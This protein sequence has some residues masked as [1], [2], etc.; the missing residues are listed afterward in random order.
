M[1]KTHI[2]GIAA[3]ALGLALPIALVPATGS[4]AP[5][6]TPLVSVAQAPAESEIKGQYIVTVKAGNDAAA[7]AQAKSVRT[8][9]VYDEVINGFA[10]SLTS[11]QLAALRA[12]K[13]I[14]SIEEDQ[15][16]VSKAT[17]NNAPWGLDRIDQRSGRN[18]TYT[19]NGTGAG[20]TAYI[21][22]SGIYTAHPD[23]GN[24][25]RNVFDAFGGNGQDCNGHGTHV[26]GTV[27]G[28]VHGVAK[29]VQLRGVK[30]LNCQGSGSFSAIIAGFDWVRQNA[31]K[32]AVAN[33][34]LGGGYSAALN[35]AATALANSGVHTTVAAGN[36]NQNA[37][38]YSPASAPG[39]LSIAASDSADNKASFSNFGNCTDLYGPGVGV[40]STRMGGGTTSMSGTSMAAPHVA[41]VAALY[42]GAYGEASSTTVNNWIINNST[43]NAIRGNVTGT[44]NRLLFK[45]TL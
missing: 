7:V 21:I 37:C 31:V 34:S 14:A 43:A 25:A 16:V 5:V 10:A 45:S 27:G 2:S 18:T 6:P 11:S 23:F 36:N 22:D 44:P 29:G 26:A 28:S 12:D 1:R 32:P 9:Y 40:V 13:R 24:R 41:G 30:V 35:N 39:A 15:K 38:N 42:K 3:G 20:V 19:Y 17:Q 4:A 33:A 8:D